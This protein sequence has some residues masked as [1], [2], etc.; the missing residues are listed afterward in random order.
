MS[1]KPKRDSPSIRDIDRLK[2]EQEGR[3]DER[4][5]VGSIHERSP[6]VNRTGCYLINLTSSSIAGPKDRLP[7]PT[8]ACGKGVLP[9]IPTYRPKGENASKS[10]V[11]APRERTQ[12]PHRLDRM[13]FEQSTSASQRGGSVCSQHGELN[14]FRQ[15]TS[16]VGRRQAFD[17]LAVE[18]ASNISNKSIQQIRD[19]IL[20]SLLAERS[21]SADISN[22]NIGCTDYLAIEKATPPL[23]HKPEEWFRLNGIH[24]RKSEGVSK[25]VLRKEREF[26]SPDG[27]FMVDKAGR[28]ARRNSPNGWWWY[29]I[30]NLTGTLGIQYRQNHRSVQA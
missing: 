30:G 27:L 26:V 10:Q 12:N 9:A 1:E 13:R 19:Q 15:I 22:K 3:L 23:L 11:H 25:D 6:V 14:G 24:G 21:L 4:A 17:G 8:T 29:W 7:I 2:C 18:V 20:E 16:L 5:V 28:T